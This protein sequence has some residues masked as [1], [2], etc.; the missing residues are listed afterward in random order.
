ML[1]IWRRG[2]GYGSKPCLA[3]LVCGP[4]DRVAALRREGLR[5]RLRLLSLPGGYPGAGWPG[6]EQ[7]QLL[8][9]RQR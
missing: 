9:A 7:L 6:L 4:A 3:G 2:T 1:R 5:L 8:A